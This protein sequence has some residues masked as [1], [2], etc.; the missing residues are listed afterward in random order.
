MMTNLKI[1]KKDNLRAVDK[2]TFRDYHPLGRLVPAFK[3]PGLT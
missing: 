3:D 1:F 2:G